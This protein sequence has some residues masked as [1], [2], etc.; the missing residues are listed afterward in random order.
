MIDNDLD[1][2]REELDEFAKPKKSQSRSSEEERVIAGFEEIQC[3]Y[4]EH[5]RVPQNIEDRNIFERIY[6]IRLEQIKKQPS[7]FELLKEFDESNL[8]L[9]SKESKKNLPDNLDDDELL[10]ELKDINSEIQDLHNLKFV[11][12]RKEINAPER[13]AKRIPCIDFHKFKPLFELLQKELNQ[14]IRQTKRYKAS[15]LMREGEFFILSGQKVYIAEVGELFYSDTQDRQDARL[16]LIFDNGVESDLLMSSLERA[17]QKDKS[18][19][20]ISENNPGPLFSDQVSEDDV[21]SGIIYI[22][23][24]K[25][26]KD[27]IK[28]NKDVI[29]KIGVTSGSVEKRIANASQEA[30]FLLAEVEVVAT[31]SLYN[32][33]RTKLETLLHRLF[34]SAR[35]DIEIKD[36]FGN[37]VKPEEWFL[38]S[39][40]VIK[41]AIDKLKDGT[42]TDYR[43]NK[44]SGS[45]EKKNDTKV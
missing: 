11:K 42:I 26:E 30:T 12:P 43:Y 29:H 1:E 4:K 23:R 39:L 37:P 44:K 34:H 24:S 2:L 21:Q 41:K 31:F 8:L 5:D 3:F 32:I 28:N 45:L 20:R 40:P 22:L 27:Y 6:A 35:L 16:R 33:N 25:S 17:L 36:R 7:Y 9:I 14:N 15:G 13:S 38:V 19:R 18:G 10:N